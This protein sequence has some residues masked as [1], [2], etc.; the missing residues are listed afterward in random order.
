MA[1][2]NIHGQTERFMK[3]IGMEEKYQER[4]KSFGHRGQNM[5]VISLGA[6]FMVLAPLLELMGLFTMGP[7]G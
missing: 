2:V 4:G 3:G 1:K 5:R 6:I 7:G